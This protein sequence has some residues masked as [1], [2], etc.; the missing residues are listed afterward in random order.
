VA[1]PDQPSLGA[2]EPSGFMHETCIH[3]PA[4]A[5]GVAIA[6]VSSPAHNAAASIDRRSGAGAPCL[7]H[8]VPRI[9]IA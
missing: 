2:G 1:A 4:R 9:A 3:W 7:R 8:P 6:S 5:G